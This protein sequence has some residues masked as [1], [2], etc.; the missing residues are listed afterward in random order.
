[1]FLSP[2]TRVPFHVQL[3]STR[4]SHVI[5]ETDLSFSEV[6]K[7]RRWGPSPS[8]CVRTVLWWPVSH[9]CPSVS[10]LETRG[11]PSE[12]WDRLF[13]KSLWAEAKHQE[14]SCLV[15]SPGLATRDSVS[16]KKPTKKTPPGHRE[17]ALPNCLLPVPLH[18]LP[19]GLYKAD[20]RFGPGIETHPDG[21][22]DVGLWFRQ[23]LI[24]LC[25]AV[26]GGFTVD[27]RPELSGFCTRVPARIRLS[28]GEAMGWGLHEGQ[29]PF[30]YEFK[31]FLL[32]DDLTLPPEMF[33]YSTDSGHLPMTRS[34]RKELDA[35]I[36]AN[37]I[38]PF[39]EDGEPW[40]V[41]NETPLL[42]RIQEHA[43]KFRAAGR[44]PPSRGA[45]LPPTCPLS[46]EAV[47]RRLLAEPAARGD[48]GWCAALDGAWQETR[49]RVVGAE[50]KA[51]LWAPR[52]GLLC[53]NKK[54]HSSWNM[55]AILEGDREGF[56]CSGPKERFS[57][58]M[59]LKAEEGDH[60]WIQ[61]VLRDNFASAD[62]AD[63]KGY[64]ALAAAAVSPARPRPAPP[65]PE[66]AGSSAHL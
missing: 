29:D 60:D 35:R 37:D 22:Q 27:S 62:V 32:N 12:K 50:G 10:L 66:G 43:Y 49:A 20:E 25:T 52:T 61:G 3:P 58:E 65:S 13:K 5:L 54:A 15:S 1:M 9:T 2:C 42:V 11:M 6:G 57:Q 28:D 59:I 40:F 46:G 19:Q 51:W 7:D 53:R 33:V 55:G 21:S 41:A 36:F 26:S 31:R 45:S 44:C 16:K 38:P 18:V 64:T 63:S 4:S 47:V 24:K 48:R 23:H 8:P 14:A 39:V 30:F 17:E 34:F 56:A